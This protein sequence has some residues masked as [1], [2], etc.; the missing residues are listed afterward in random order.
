MNI[1]DA[2]AAVDKECETSGSCQHG[3]TKVKCKKVVT[4]QAQ[5]R[6]KDSSFCNADG[7]MPPQVQRYTVRIVLRG[8]VVKDDSGSYA[9]FA[10]QGSSASQVTA[11]MVLDAMAR[12]PECAGQVE[13][14]ADTEVKMEHVTRLPKLPR[15]KQ[16]S[17]NRKVDPRV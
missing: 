9:V 10:E 12:P 6:G 2:K 1:P 16:S 3:E 13:V 5:K 15:T 14:S 11:A 4:E 8:D 7:L 17:R